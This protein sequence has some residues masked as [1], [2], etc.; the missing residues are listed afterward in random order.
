MNQVDEV[1]DVL[2][3]IKEPKIILKF[4]TILSIKK[5]TYITVKLPKSI[6]KK[7]LYSI[8]K[9]INMIIIQI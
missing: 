4:S 5:G 7:D 9:V 6:T 1:V 2:P 8:A 3:Y